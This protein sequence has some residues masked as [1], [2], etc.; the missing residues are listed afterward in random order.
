F[1]FQAEDGIR[2]YKVTG[3]QTCALPISPGR[4]R[5]IANIPGL[6]A[7]ARRNGARRGAGGCVPVP[8]RIRVEP[9]RPTGGVDRPGGLP[10][11]LHRSEERRVGNE[12]ALWFTRC[13][14][15]SK[16]T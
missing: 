4:W 11:L 6:A 7:A 12:A 15:R 1:F 14:F 3:V 10:A 5:H 8:L 2:D 13:Q 9:W 16:G